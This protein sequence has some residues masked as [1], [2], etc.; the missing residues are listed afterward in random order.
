MS[1]SQTRPRTPPSEYGPSLTPPTLEEINLCHVSVDVEPSENNVNGSPPPVAEDNVVA[2]MQTEEA[3]GDSNSRASDRIPTP[4]LITIY[5][6]LIVYAMF[7]A[8]V[9]IILIRLTQVSVSF[10]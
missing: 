7:M 6:G 10:L 4:C 9:I 8:A 5:L 2:S 3:N 1:T